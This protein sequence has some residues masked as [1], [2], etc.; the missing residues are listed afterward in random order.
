MILP[1][2]ENTLSQSSDKAEVARKETASLYKLGFSSLL[3][4]LIF[5]SKPTTQLLN[6]LQGT[7]C[8]DVPKIFALL[9]FEQILELLRFYISFF[10]RLQLDVSSV[11]VSLTSSRIMSL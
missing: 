7:F 9:E 6:Q 11:I 5:G 1:A 10:V 2:L 3:L 4:P 8:R